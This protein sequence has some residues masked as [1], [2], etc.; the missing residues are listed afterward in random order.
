[1]CQAREEVHTGTG[2]LRHPC[3]RALGRVVKVAGIADGE[4]EGNLHGVLVCSHIGERPAL[5]LQL[6]Y[7]LLDGCAR[8]LLRG[9]LQ[10]VGDDGDNDHGRGVQQQG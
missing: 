1:M 10:T 3:H 4:V 9:I 7:Q 5:A 6:L 8:V 2:V